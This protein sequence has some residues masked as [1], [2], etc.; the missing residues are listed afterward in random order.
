MKKEV[1]AWGIYDLANTAFSSL[2][3]TFFFPLFIKVFLN[4]NEFQIGLSFG[5]SMLFVALIVPFIGALSDVLKKR[6]PFIIFFTI[7]CV[8]AT[9]FVPY[10]KL[11]LALILGGVANFAYHAA[12]TTYN[13]LIPELINKKQFGRLSGF[14]VSFGY[15]GNFLSIGLAA[16]LLN[17]LGWDSI[18]GINA[19]F[20]L[21]AGFFLVFS[22]ITFLMIKEKSKTKLSKK[23]FSDAFA[24]LKKTFKNIKKNRSLIYY[25]LSTFLIMNAVSAA[26]VFLYLFG[27]ERIGLSIP[28]YMIIF[29][30]FSITAIMGSIIFGRLSDKITAKKSL[31]IST[32]IWIITIIILIFVS[33]FTSFLIAGLIGGVAW[34]GVIAGVR[35]LLLDITP[36]NKV[37]E[38]FGFSELAN[39]FSGIIGPIAFGGFVVLYN[40]T[41]ALILLLLFFILGGIFLQKCQKC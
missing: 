15:A 41:A 12:L 22:S 4:G 14:G 40:Y 26:I 8:L 35:P 19:M 6:M 31:T 21:T 20:L 17:Y 18:K 9:I 16:L 13:A 25:L 32:I 3:I 7:I 28:D 36:K 1:L 38:Y 39:K 5:I 34:G 27:R 37:G 10:S 30:L 23:K 33:D 29:C 11:T 24:E 2:F